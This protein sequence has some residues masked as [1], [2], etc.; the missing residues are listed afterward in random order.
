VQKK[1][2]NSNKVE[3]DKNLN[4]AVARFDPKVIP[5]IEEVNMFREDATVLNMRKPTVKYAFK[6]QLLVVQGATET[7]TLKSM[8]PEV[9][10]QVGPKELKHLSEIVSAMGGA[11]AEAAEEDEDDAPPELVGTFEDAAKK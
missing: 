7:K 3:E 5:E 11:K 9:M 6:E 10:K 1:K 4:K 2:P 8:M